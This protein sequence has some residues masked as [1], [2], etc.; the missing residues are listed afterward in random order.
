MDKITVYCGWRLS[1]TQLNSFIAELREHVLSNTADWLSRSIRASFASTGKNMTL[2]ALVER[3]QQ[4]F[5][6]ARLVSQESNEADS[7]YDL[8]YSIDIYLQANIAYV[9]AHGSCDSD[10]HSKYAEDYS[11]SANMP[12][13]ED[14][15]L[16]EWLQRAQDWG[17]VLYNSEAKRL[18]HYI[19]NVD[20]D[21]G[22]E[23][24]WKRIY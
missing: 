24:V 11:Y 3:V 17:Q 23:E 2:L 13:P 9:I 15:P 10:F 16:S 19:I 1:A 7:N 6:K 12:R 18:V 8:D 21:I 5:D 14:V 22:V 20:Q 4:Y